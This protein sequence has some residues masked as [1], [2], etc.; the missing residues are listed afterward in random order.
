LLLR[1]LETPETLPG[2]RILLP[3]GVRDDLT[4]CQMEVV[5]VGDDAVCDNED[6][7]REHYA[8][9]D[10]R[11]YHVCDARVRAG[12]WV[13]LEPRRLADAGEDGLYLCNHDDVIAV[14]THDG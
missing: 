11:R 14:V 9:W 6:C 13:L 7:E 12:A 1:K 8:R 10:D 5:A 4:S 2:G 3:E